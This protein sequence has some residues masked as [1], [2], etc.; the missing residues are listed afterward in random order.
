MIGAVIRGIGKT[1]GFGLKAVNFGYR[2]SQKMKGEREAER[3][4]EAIRLNALHIAS[5]GGMNP[6]QAYLVARAA[7]QQGLIVPMPEAPRVS[8]LR[9]GLYNITDRL[10]SEVSD[11]ML[12]YA[13]KHLTG[14]RR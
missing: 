8:R 3:L 4:E 7:A 1:V 2:Y 5:Q 13:G 6:I 11:G 14:A 12:R 9:T 10:T